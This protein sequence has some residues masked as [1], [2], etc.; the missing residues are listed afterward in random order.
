MN[1]E[2]LAKILKAMADPSRLKIVDLLSCGELCACEILE[3]FD[4]TQPTLSYHMQILEKANIVTITKKSQWKYYNLCDGFKEKFTEKLDDLL[5]DSL[6][7][8]CHKKG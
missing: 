2:E 5:C 6:D 1:Y 8:I 3:H 7:C 4:F